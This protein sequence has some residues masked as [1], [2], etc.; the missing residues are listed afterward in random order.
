[1]QVQTVPVAE[2][3]GQGVP[4]S[5]VCA[6]EAGA[7]VVGGVAFP[8]AA[9]TGNGSLLL[10][11]RSGMLKKI[12]LADLPMPASQTARVMTVGEGDQL[13]CARLAVPESEIVLATSAGLAIRFRSEQVRAMGL[14]AAGVQGIKLGGV[15]DRV[16]GMDVA[17]ARGDV[18]LVTASGEGKR[19][20]VEDLPLQGRN[21][22]G[23]TALK[24]AGG[25]L[26]ASAV[27]GM[28]DDDVAVVTAAGKAKVVKLDKLPRRT[29][30]VRPT[31]R[32]ARFLIA[33]MRCSVRSIPARLS[34]PKSPMR[35]ITH[36]RSSSVT[37]RSNSVTSP[38]VSRASGRRPR[39]MTTSRSPSR[40]AAS[41]SRVES[42]RIL[43]TISPGR[44]SR[45]R[46][47]LSTIA[48]SCTT[49]GASMGL[50]PS[51]GVLASLIGRILARRPAERN[52]LSDRG[53]HPW[54]SHPRPGVTDGEA[55][56][57]DLLKAVCA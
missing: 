43:A 37:S 5:S 47:R 53:D 57:G 52:G 20:A 14:A 44:Q 56:I 32:S 26:L 17:R 2:E 28:A 35:E 36:E 10:A 51:C 12:A 1:M 50:V 31:T 41:S 45:R 48:S 39:S 29:R 16:V 54:G 8:P 15:H 46:S 11:A 25:G 19:I 21:G 34:P 4:W 13:I 33:E 3:V 55:E 38:E 49:V 7:R 27:V 40:P 24:L 22:K 6:L 42:S 9:R 30:Q 23:V 18:L